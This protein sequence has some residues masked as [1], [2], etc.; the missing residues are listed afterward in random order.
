MRSANGIF[1][2]EYAAGDAN[3]LHRLRLKSFG[4]VIGS[5]ESS[6][7]EDLPCSQKCAPSAPA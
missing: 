7:D 2:I 3:T 1:P 6:V 5:P 4:V